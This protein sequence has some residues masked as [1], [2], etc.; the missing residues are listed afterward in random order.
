VIDGL[1]TTPLAA[2]GLQWYRQTPYM[3]DID[4]APLI[5]ATI[6]TKKSWETIPQ[7]SRASLSAAGHELG[8]SLAKQIPGLD[9]EAVQ[10]MVKRGLTVVTPEDTGDHVAAWKK[11]ADQ[12]ATH[13]RG[14]M[15]P[16]DVYDLAVK[17]REEF[18]ARAEP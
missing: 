6:V 17:A 15:V 2:L 1:T 3:I 10:E 16:A 18:R 4:L 12:L 11:L 14:T 8:E 13:M 9:D 5:G 7:G